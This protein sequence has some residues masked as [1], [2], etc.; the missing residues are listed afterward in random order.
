MTTNTPDQAKDLGRTAQAIDD[1][2]TQLQPHIH[3]YVA[4]GG[5][6]T[7]LVRWLQLAIVSGGGSYADALHTTFLRNGGIP[8]PLNAPCPRLLSV[9]PG[10]VHP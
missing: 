4:Q 5:D 1:L 10:A 8:Q 3:A 6:H 2:A 7:T 9:T